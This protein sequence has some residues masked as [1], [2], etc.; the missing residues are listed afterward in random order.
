MRRRLRRN[1]S[2]RRPLFFVMVAA[3]LFVAS[4]SVALS[5]T[6]GRRRQPAPRRATPAIDYSRFS[7]S[8]EKHRQACGTCHKVPTENW[9]KTSSFPDI[10]DYPDHAACVS[11][12]RAQFFRGTRPVICTNCHTQVSPRADARL[13]FRNTK[14]PQ[15]FTIE[16]PHDRHQ[17]VIANLLQR[18]RRLENRK[19]GFIKTSFAPN[20]QDVKN[21]NNCTICHQPR[22]VPVFSGW[23]DG[24]IPDALTFKSVLLDHASCFNCHWKEQK[25]VRD[26]CDGCHKLATGPITHPGVP[27]RISMKFKHDG[28]GEKRNHVAECTTCHI[29][30]TKSE[31]LRGLKP[32]VPITSCSEC[33]NKDG[34]RLDLAGELAKLDKDKAFVCSYCHTSDVGRRDAPAGHYL[35][36]GR[37]PK[38]R[39]DLE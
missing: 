11:C 27:V 4:V 35:V 20:T 17:D 12:H 33:H 38:T 24:Y 28:G 22:A 1:M 13:S 31:S 36:S 5:Q 14:V 16:F 2:V 6:R 18:V 19:P 8:T 30:I 26:N 10:T 9:Q 29:N 37:D 15:Q 7:H 3:L 32:D 23:S 39:K 21:Y 34:L 25:P